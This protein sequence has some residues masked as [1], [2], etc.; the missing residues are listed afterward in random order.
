MNSKNVITLICI[1]IYVFFF[2]VDDNATKIFM[3]MILL[4]KFNYLATINLSVL[5]NYFDNP[6]KIIF[7][8]RYLAKFLDTLAK[9]FFACYYDFKSNLI[10]IYLAN[11]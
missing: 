3:L 6:N 4:Q 11:Y 8:P 10:N 7:R 9:L 1:I 5:Y 2:F